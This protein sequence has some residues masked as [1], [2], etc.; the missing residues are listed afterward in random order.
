MVAT[1]MESWMLKIDYIQCILAAKLRRRRSLN[2]V[3]R[4]ID[5]EIQ[6]SKIE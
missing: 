6:K 2:R 3:E 1:I 5:S 4:S